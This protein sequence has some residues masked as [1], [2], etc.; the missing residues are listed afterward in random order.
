MTSRASSARTTSWPR[1]SATLPS[2][3]SGSKSCCCG[4]PSSTP[5]PIRR[6]AAL[7]KKAVAQSKDQ[8]INVRFEQLVELLGKDQLSR[9]IDN[10]AELNQDLRTL[11]DLLMSENRAKQAELEKARVPRIPQAG[12]RNHPPGKGHSSPHCRRRRNETAGPEA[13]KSRRQNGRIG[14]RYACK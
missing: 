9:A 8:L 7:L 13:G 14:T 11:L 12:Q 10:Q 2:D 1:S 6:R 5:S 4:W 3:T